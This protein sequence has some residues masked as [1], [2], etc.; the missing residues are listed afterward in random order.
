MLGSARAHNIAGLARTRGE[1][2]KQ[3]KYFLRGLRGTSIFVLVSSLQSFGQIFGTRWQP[4]KYVRLI[5]PWL[6]L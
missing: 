3:I 1:L 6:E 2:P 4:Q 5:D